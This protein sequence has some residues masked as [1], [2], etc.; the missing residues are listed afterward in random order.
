MEPTHNPESVR[1]G[2][3]SS[4]RSSSLKI[5]EQGW[6][7]NSIRHIAHELTVLELKGVP[8]MWSSRKYSGSFKRYTTCLKDGKKRGYQMREGR[9]RS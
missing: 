3:S 4:S 7:E 9:T 2:V 8:A 1:A 5:N 6:G